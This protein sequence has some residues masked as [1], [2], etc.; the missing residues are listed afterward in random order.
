MMNQPDAS[1]DI[2]RYQIAYAGKG[3][4]QTYRMRRLAEAFPDR[5]RIL[6][7]ED[8]GKP[9]RGSSAQ[10]IGDFHELSQMMSRMFGTGRFYE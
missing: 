10:M 2:P 1:P 4:G 3:M 7:P 5:V 9:I 8:A 6:T